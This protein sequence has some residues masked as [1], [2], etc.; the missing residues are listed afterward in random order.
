MRRH[1]R[2][3]H[4]IRVAAG[5]GADQAVVANVEQGEPLPRR[6][7]FAGA[8]VSGSAALVTERADWSEQS[9]RWLRDA[10]HEG[11]PLLG[12][13]YGHQLL[14]HALGGEVG[15]NPV[16]RES[17]TIEVELDASA[18]DDPLFGR[19][20]ARFSAHASHVQTVT[21][22]P[23]QAVLLARSG[24]DPCQAFRWGDRAWGVQFHPEF[25]A[26]HMRGYVAARRQALLDEG[27]CPRTLEREVTAA[28]QARK[29]LRHFVGHAR[30]NP[31]RRRP[32]QG[33]G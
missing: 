17:G 6:E 7:G 25:A 15:D 32:V 26:H 5:L 10:A 18:G 19:M 14:A 20:P 24:R 2:F 30:A 28:P 16:G 27:Q 33:T 22:L 4:W 23:P 21:R 8:I 11:L 29:L 9:A 13:C 31:A 1:G 12:I 3:S